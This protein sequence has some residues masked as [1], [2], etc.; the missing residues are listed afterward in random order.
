[1]SSV[2]TIKIAFQGGGAKL[3]AML[4]AAAAFKKCHDDGTICIST[5]SGA[6]AGSICA[7]LIASEINFNHVINFLRLTGLGSIDRIVSQDAKRL[8]EIVNESWWGKTKQIAANLPFIY[9]VL[10]G[11]HP[12]LDE[13]E[14]A[15]FIKGLFESA[16]YKKVEDTKIKLFINASDIVQQEN[17]YIEKGYI[18]DAVIDSASIPLAFR[19]FRAL[20]RTHVVDGGLCQNLPADILLKDSETADQPIFAVFPEIADERRE[21]SNILQYCFALF[22]ASITHNVQRS[23]DQISKAFSIG[24]PCNY[25]TFDFAE[26]L[27][28]LKDENWYIRSFMEYEAQIRDFARNYGTLQSQSHF[29]FSDID[30]KREYIDAV[31]AL[32]DNYLDYVDYKY[33]RFHVVVNCDRFIMD[34]DISF[35]RPADNIVKTA[36]FEVKKAG[37][38]YFR[39]FLGADTQSN[40]A[41][42]AI[43][44][45][46]NLTKKIELDIT[47]LALN[48]SKGAPPGSGPA[49][50]VMFKKAETTIEVGDEI[51]IVDSSYARDGMLDMNKRRN[52]SIGIMNSHDISVGKVELVITYPKRLGNYRMINMIEDDSLGDSYVTPIVFDDGELRNLSPELNIIGLQTEKLPPNRRFVGLAVRS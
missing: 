46:R 42:P 52:D 31:Q 28:T 41:R 11:G 2:P 29:R 24:V 30:S 1:M 45:A 16:R 48:R 34:D 25:N 33:T 18:H 17:R 10:L 27:R 3:I 43:W 5:V 7:A 20:S 21:I 37:F 12:I 39:S 38:H 49:C 14:F 44:T 35:H 36:R 13:R 32:T 22:S 15:K 47:V 4:P 40:T 50:V 51:E 26:A 19:S 9:R 23:R 8:S 6:S